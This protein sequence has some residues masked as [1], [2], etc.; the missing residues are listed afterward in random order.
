M[1][2]GYEIVY[3]DPPWPYYGRTDKDAAAGKHYDLMAIEDIYAVDHGGGDPS[4]L[5]L[6]AT[7]PKLHYAVEAMRRYL[8]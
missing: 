2:G 3:A 1:S 8:A 7:G 6:W 5:F 4:A